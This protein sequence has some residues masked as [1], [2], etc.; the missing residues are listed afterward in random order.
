MP[1]RF[2]R[3]FSNIPWAQHPRWNQHAAL[4]NDLQRASSLDRWASERWRVRLVFTIYVERS[5][6]EHLSDFWLKSKIIYTTTVII[7]EYFG[8]S[9]FYE[10]VI[11]TKFESCMYTAT[12]LAT[13]E[14]TDFIVNTGSKMPT[15]RKAPLY[16]AGKE[17]EC[18][19]SKFV[20]VPVTYWP[21]TSLSQFHNWWQ[22]G[23]NVVLEIKEFDYPI[24]LI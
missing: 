23:K 14:W 24:I 8:A 22:G 4:Q 9:V 5:F 12:F 6:S 18:Q 19:T 20:S 16:R 21:W 2:C 15:R 13:Y 1:A 7:F 11:F 17:H 3:G 10:H